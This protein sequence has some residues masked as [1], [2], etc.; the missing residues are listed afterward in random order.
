MWQ[1]PEDFQ[2]QYEQRFA[3]ALDNAGNALSAIVAEVTN[4]IEA[5]TDGCRR[6][7]R[8]PA[9]Y[10]VKA[11]ATVESLAE[12]VADY[13][14]YQ[15]NI[16]L[17]LLSEALKKIE[18]YEWED[19]TPII[20]NTPLNPYYNRQTTKLS[21]TGLKLP[22][23]AD[24][25]Q[26]QLTAI[27]NF[28]HQDV[29]KGQAEAKELIQLAKQFYAGSKLSGKQKETWNLQKVPVPAQFNHTYQFWQEALL[30]HY[31]AEETETRLQQ[32]AD[33]AKKYPNCIFLNSIPYAN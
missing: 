2:E 27:L 32:L 7:G 25:T 29:E 12:K 4:V 14:N 13:I 10:M 8:V 3:V 16:F 5:Y 6:N 18:R 33:A 9:K 22:W 1:T 26:Q 21:N 28:L 30:R 15:E 20:P 24:M 23:W 11:Q 19:E 31:T 17:N